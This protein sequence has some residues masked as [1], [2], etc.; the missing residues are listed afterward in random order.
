MSSAAHHITVIGFFFFIKATVTAS[1]YLSILHNYAFLQKEAWR[2]NNLQ[3]DDAP[4]HYGNTV[5]DA[6][7]MRL[8]DQAGLISWLPSHPIWQ[9]A[10]FFL[11][12]LHAIYG[13][14]RCTQTPITT[15][16]ATVTPEM[17]NGV[18]NET[19]FQPDICSDTKGIHMEI[20][21]NKFPT[22][23]HKLFV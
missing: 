4:P 22:V 23:M 7:N 16:T 5:H 2:V 6:L 8:P 12:G 9:H 18:W 19:Q 17:L 21:N 20:Y 10:L 13:S 3:Y 11:F 15:T 14:A 1:T